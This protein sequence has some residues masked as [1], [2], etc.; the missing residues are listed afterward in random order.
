M[1]RVGRDTRLDMNNNIL[2]PRFTTTSEMLS[3]VEDIERQIWL[4]DHMLLMPK[5]EAWIRREVQVQRAVGTTQIEG[6]KLDDAAVRRLIREGGGRNPTEDEQANLNA[7]QAYSFVDFLSAQPDIPIDELVI[8]QLN[9]F[10]MDG[11]PDTLTPGVYRKGQNKI[12]NYIPPNQG[13]VPGLMRSLALWLRRQDDEVHPVVRAGMG[14]IQTV[15][16]HPFWDGNGRTARAIATLILQR[17]PFSF[18]NL[19]SLEGYL[20]QNRDEYFSAI[21][22]TLGTQYS[23]EYDATHWLEFYA[24]ALRQHIQEFVA[25]LTN[26]HREMQEV[27]SDSAEKGWTARQADGLVFA[28]Q[29][30]QITRADYIEITG[31]SPVTA[32]RDLAQM[33]E[34][35]M[36]LPIGKT[37][38]RVYYPVSEDSALMGGPAAEQLPLLSQ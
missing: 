19:L 16:I 29:A 30:G 21:E 35:G 26:W 12:R 34:A 15:A 11:A 23:Q 38:A 17:S 31:V 22:R 20:S 24:L 27:Y 37:R 8:R 18:R 3:A 33:V 25:G 5:H 9:R 6:A 1:I 4:V 32:S 14:H 7:L 28:Y 10:F 13:D 36:L 2:N